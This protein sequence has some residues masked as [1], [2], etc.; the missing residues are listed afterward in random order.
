MVK[1]YKTRLEA[2]TA[3]GEESLQESLQGPLATIV[4]EKLL[5]W[6]GMVY[7]RQVNFASE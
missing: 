4:G 6:Q 3:L 7:K 5:N 1:K 2:M